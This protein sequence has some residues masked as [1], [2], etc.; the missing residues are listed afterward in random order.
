MNRLERNIYDLLKHLGEDPDRAG[1]RETPH[2]FVRALEEM[3]SGYT[4]EPQSV[5][6]WFEEEGTN[7]NSLIM[8][9][10][11]P[12]YST[13]EHHLLPFFGEVTIGYVA[14]GRVLGLS[15]FARLVEVFA[16]RLQVQE[17]LTEQIADALQNSQGQP[18]GVGVLVSA[19][20]TCMAAR[21]VCKSG[22]L[23]IS[24][25]LRGC[26]KDES[27]CRAEFLKLAEAR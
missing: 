21:G 5:L 11:I 9:R 14:S 17:R 6:K 19:E 2:R 10:G 16:K 20:H 26:V 18:L 22:A 1:L 25:A 13:C 15:K 23:T 24:S 3:T 27:A 4:V 7:S 12:F 8:V